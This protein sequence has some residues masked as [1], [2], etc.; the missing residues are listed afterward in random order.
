MELLLKHGADINAQPGV[1]HASFILGGGR[2][3]LMWAAY[4]G[5]SAAMRLLIDAGADVNAP[6]MLGSPLSQAAWADHTEAARLL[7]EHGAKPNQPD[8]FT[9]YTPLHWAASTESG[10]P[11]LVKLLLT[12]GADPNQGA[13]ENVDAFMGTPQTPLML[14]GRR[15][16]SPILATLREAGATNGAPD[17]VRQFAA[18]PAELPERLEPSLIRAAIDQAIAP[19][20]KTALESKQAFVRHA[21]A[22]DCISCHQQML[23]MT[24]TGLARK[25]GATVDSQAE[26]ELIKLVGQ[27]ELKNSEADWQ[28]LFHPDPVHTKGYT[29]L[30][31][32]AEDIP[33]SELSDSAVH[34]LAAIQ[35]RDGQWFNNLPRPPIQTGDIAATALAVQALQHYPLPGRRAEFAQR[36]ERARQWLWKVHPD[37]TE[38]RAYQLLGLA[39][40]GEPAEKLKALAQP[41]A[42]EQR[43][44]GGWAQLPGLAADAYATGQAVYALRIAAGSPTSDPTVQRGLRFLLT[45]QLDDGTWYVHRRAFPFQPTMDSGFP[46]GRDSW[47]SAAGSSWAAMA[48]SVALEPDKLAKR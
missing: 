39:W 31:L 32:S 23:P 12:H 8:P 27:G 44:D 41:L 47:I 36:V 1:D 25:H 18:R 15:G 33:A 9:T 2:S 16:G 21:S 40:S 35:G 24:A 28:S 34:H 4:R 45:T 46:H 19:L 6:G 30:A 42:A 38:N 7:I 13:G 17:R 22:Q 3:A 5:D 26:A 10:N 48:L 43:N 20:Q 29:L 11:E 37:N 14:A